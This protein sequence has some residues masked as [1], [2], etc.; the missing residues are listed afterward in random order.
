MNQ[1]MKDRSVVKAD[2]HFIYFLKIG[3]SR[4]YLGVHYPSDVVGGYL[5]GAAWL[6]ICI[7]IFRYYEYCH[8]LQHI[9]GKLTC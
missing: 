7:L 4:I 9:V 8:N 5:A 1:N 2:P 3:V 6:L